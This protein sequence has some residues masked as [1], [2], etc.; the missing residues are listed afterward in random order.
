MYYDTEQLLD[1]VGC[2]DSFYRSCQ[3]VDSSTLAKRP[4][5][6][7]AANHLRVP[8]VR[9]RALKQAS[10]VAGAAIKL[11]CTDTDG[12]DYYSGEFAIQ[13]IDCVSFSAGDTPYNRGNGQTGVII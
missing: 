1:V 5:F 9:F 10:T 6:D 11:K 2:D 12:T 13:E 8:L 4:E 3:I 7:L